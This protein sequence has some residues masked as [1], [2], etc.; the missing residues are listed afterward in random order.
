MLAYMLSCIII[1]RVCAYACADDRVG[2]TR[3]SASTLRTESRTCL[4]KRARP[5]M[6]N[7]VLRMLLL[8]HA[9]T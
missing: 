1:D 3:L 6:M 2:N 8:H 9:A 5:Q 4:V 7:R